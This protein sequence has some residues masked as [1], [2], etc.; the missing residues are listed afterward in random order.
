MSRTYTARFERIQSGYLGQLIE[1][2]EVVTEGVTLEECRL[3][4]EDAAR[5]MTIAY[6]ENGLCIPEPADVIDRI[7]VEA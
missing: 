7:L 5:E 1:W 6:R 2:P 3:M 4:L